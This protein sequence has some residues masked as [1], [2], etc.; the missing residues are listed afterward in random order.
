MKQQLSKREKVLLLTAALLVLFYLAIQFAIL[1]MIESYNEAQR[2]R[3]RLAR[4]KEEVQFDIDNIDALRSMSVAAD[5]RFDSL[6]EIFPILVD[7]EK[8]DTILTNLCLSNGLKPTTLRMT[9]PPPP[10][11]TEGDENFEKPLFTIV[12]ATMNVTGDYSSL[13][14]LLDEIDSIEYIRII[15]L[16]YSLSRQAETGDDSD[17]TLTFELTFLTP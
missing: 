17:I 11:Q 13:L 5:E 6:K 12:T 7:D 4:E 14:K 10:Q 8:I 3:D 1:P 16:A 9:I 2:E 15:N